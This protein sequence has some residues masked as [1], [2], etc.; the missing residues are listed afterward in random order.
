MQLQNYVKTF[1]AAEAITE[2]ALVSF[3]GNGK[4]TITDA[5]TEISCVGVAQ[6]A[7]NAGEVV[8]VVVF[9]ETK[10]IASAGITFNT[11]PLLT[12]A[13]NGQVAAVSGSSN[14][15]PVARILPNINQTSTAGAGEQILVLF[16]GPSVVKA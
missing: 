3:D 15:Y 14:E 6:R 7:C 9:G 4:V 2:F 12:G 5:G 13:A 16:T 8:D 11:N 1:V 10:V